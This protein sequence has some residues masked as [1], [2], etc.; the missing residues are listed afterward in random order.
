MP[1]PNTIERIHDWLGTTRKRA[2]IYEIMDALSLSRS[3]VY[4]SLDILIEAGCV[5]KR[6]LEP[7][8]GQHGKDPCDYAAI[9]GATRKQPEPVKPPESFP[10]ALIEQ[11]PSIFHYA[12]RCMAAARDDRET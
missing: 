6:T 11:C 1:H 4:Q 5:E 12:D 3:T 7:R 2:S 10:Q 8:P 9:P